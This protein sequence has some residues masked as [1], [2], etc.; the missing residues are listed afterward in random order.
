R[1]PQIGGQVIVVAANARQ[2]RVRAANR[3]LHENIV[4]KQLRRFKSVTNGVAARE[5][6]PGILHQRIEG[7]AGYPQCC[8]GAFADEQKGEGVQ[9]PRPLHQCRVLKAEGALFRNEGF[10]DKD[11][12][13]A[14]AAQAGGVPRI[15]NLALRGQVEEALPGFRNA[16]GVGTWRAVFDDGAAG[17]YPLRVLAATGERKPSFHA[18]AAR[19]TKRLARRRRR[20][21]RGNPYVGIHGTRDVLIQECADIAAV[22]TDH[23]TPADGAVSH[24]QG[25]DDAVLCQRIQ[26]RPAPRMGHH[27]AENAGVLHCLRQGWR[28]ATSLLKLL[29]CFGDPGDE[30]DRRVKDRMIVS[31]C[32]SRSPGHW[33]PPLLCQVTLI[34]RASRSRTEVC[35]AFSA[36]FRVCGF[37]LLPDLC[38]ASFARSCRRAHSRYWADGRAHLR[39]SA[40]WDGARAYRPTLLWRPSRPD[41]ADTAAHPLPA[42]PRPASGVSAATDRCV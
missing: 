5:P 16:V 9:R 27:H 10:A 33:N 25:F 23:R 2:Q 32:F 31:R 13:A 7:V 40:R 11:V 3:L 26:F 42:V 34:Q 37:S 41:F 12:I 8:S 38:G 6:F 30:V 15:E 22:T 36:P 35:F 17:P 24:R 20:G 1:R 28:N 29:A 14:R 4:A 39:L 21:G 19:H 18:I